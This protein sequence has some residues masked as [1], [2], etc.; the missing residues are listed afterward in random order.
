MGRIA[1]PFVLSQD[2]LTRIDLLVR[3][4][5]DDARKLTRAKALQFSHQGQHPE[6]ISQSLGITLTTVF[7][8]R[9]RYQ[10]EG[11]ERTLI[12]KARPGQYRKVTQQ[13]EAQITQI[14]CSE[15]PDGR[16]RWTPALIK[17]QLVKLDIH[18]GD[19]SV[20]KVLKKSKFKESDARPWLKKQWSIVQFDESI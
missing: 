5:K 9:K 10:E 20:R 4:G 19:E 11:L 16:T 12:D 13:V 6:Q 15:P 2:D 14:V 1:K 3:K 18:I 7:N 17:E 8:L